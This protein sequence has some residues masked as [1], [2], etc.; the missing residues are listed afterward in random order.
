MAS[1]RVR[2]LTRGARAYDPDVAPDG[3]TIVF[4]RKMGDR[5]ELFTTTLEG[6]RLRPLTTSARRRGVERAPLEPGR[7]GHRRRPSAPRWLARPGAGGSPHRRRPEPD[8]RPG[9]GRGAH[10]DPV[11]GGPSSFGPIVTGSPTCTP[12][13]WP[14]GRSTRV[15]NVLGG[16]FEPSVGP[17]GKTVAFADYSSRGFDIHVARLDL[18]TSSGDEPFVDRHPAPR[19]DPPPFSGAVR[20][21]PAVDHALAPLL[22]ALARRWAALRPAWERR[23]A[24]PM[25]SSATSGDCG[26][27]T[28]RR[29]GGSTPPPSTG[30][31][32]FAPRCSWPSTT[33]PT[34]SGRARSA[35]GASTPSSPGRCDGRSA[36]PR[37]WRW[38]TDA[39]ANRPSAVS[40]RTASTWVASRPRG[41]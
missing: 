25:P 9:Q 32:A 31:T 5:S 37:P 33:P 28:A 16:A 10:L 20:A 2:R 34:S 3:R 27:C 35:P 36:P 39:S 24:A 7:H 21:L 38:R 41:P 15:S 22:D 6:G 8:P 26:R 1:G 4:A 30:T 18:G 17:G 11:R 13:A 14:T 40:P 29:P 19:P 23:P 12:C